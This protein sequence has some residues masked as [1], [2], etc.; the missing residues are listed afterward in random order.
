MKG[1]VL[2]SQR[3]E[4]AYKPWV[5]LDKEK[6]YIITSHCSCTAGL[7]EA[8]SHIAALLF[9]IEAVTHCGINSEP[10]C[11]AVKCVWNDY[12]KSKVTNCIAENLD[13]SHP[14]HGKVVKR[15]SVKRPRPSELSKHEHLP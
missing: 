15:K 1:R 10:A 4:D 7:G 6:G 5:L 12:F 3:P 11:T 14:S 13:L 9:A 2:P 8:C